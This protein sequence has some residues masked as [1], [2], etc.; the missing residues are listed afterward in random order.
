MDSLDDLP[1]RLA[2][3]ERLEVAARTEPH[4]MAVTDRR[5]LV[6]SEYRTALDLPIEAL[7]RIQLDVEVGRPA[8]IVFVPHD[9]RHAPEVLAVPVEELEAVTRAV[10]IVGRRLASLG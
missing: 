4:A 10:H 3:D 5:L 6:A 7:R 2:S 9:P 1:F 8:T